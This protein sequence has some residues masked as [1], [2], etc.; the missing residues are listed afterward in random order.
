MHLAHRYRIV[1]QLGEGGMGIVYDAIDEQRGHHVALKTL[2]HPSPE[3]LYRL[4]REF[5]AMADVAHPNLV[6][7][8]DLVVGT[9]AV[10]YS[11]EVVEGVDFVS[12]CRGR[13]G[14]RAD[15]ERVR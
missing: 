2:K 14:N 3:A 12:Y 8:Y 7:L 5:R 4:K 6:Q 15:L 9:D 1:R 11:M 10:S 13:G